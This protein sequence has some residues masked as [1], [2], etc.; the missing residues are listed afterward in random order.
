MQQL[1]STTRQRPAL[2]TCLWHALVGALGRLFAGA[3]VLGYCPD[4]HRPLPPD[5]GRWPR[6]H[7][8]RILRSTCPGLAIMPSTA[9]GTLN[10]PCRPKPPV[11]PQASR[12]VQRMTRARTA[13]RGATG[14]HGATRL[15]VTAFHV[16][17]TSAPM[18]FPSSNPPALA[19]PCQAPTGAYGATR[20][21]VTAFHMA[22]A[23][24]PV[25]FR[26]SNPK[27]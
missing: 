19:T 16:A 8:R 9:E 1:A 18:W 24:A 10:L 3:L 26:S 11:S 21:K 2:P 12:L 7:S 17:M 27:D 15:K 6:L 14:A 22:M 25:W 4:N 5:R 13:L 23:S 20:T